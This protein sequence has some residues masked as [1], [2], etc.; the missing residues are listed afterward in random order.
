MK[1]IVLTDDQLR[2]LSENGGSTLMIDSR[3]HLYGVIRRELDVE[4][5]ARVAQRRQ[6][7]KEPGI[8]GDRVRAHLKA[9]E[10]E[11]ERLGG[12]SREYMHEFLERLRAEDA[13]A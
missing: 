3:G 9:L 13:K 7:P 11:W 10:A 2:V 12:F 6:L 5:L 1:E 8:P 4:Q